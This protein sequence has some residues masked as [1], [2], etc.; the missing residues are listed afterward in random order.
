YAFRLVWEALHERATLRRLV[1]HLAKPVPF[2][3][4]IYKGHPVGPLKLDLGLWLYDAMAGSQNLGRHQRLSAGAMSRMEPRLLTTDLVG[5]CF[6]YDA[7]TDDAR[8]TLE[9]ARSAWRHGADLIPFARVEEWIEEGGAVRGVRV[10]DVALDS[11]ADL[12]EIRARCLVNAT[13]PWTDGVRGKAGLERPL[14]RTTKGVHLLI[15]KARLPVPHAIVMLNQPDHRILFV[16]PWGSLVIVGT[17]DTDYDGDPGEVRASAADVDYILGILRHYFPDQKFAREDVLSTYAG[18]RPLVR[19]THASAGTTSR[20]HQILEER[21][22]LFTVAGGKLTTYR[23]MA[24]QVVDRVIGA[25]KTVGGTK[26]EMAWP[27]AGEEIVTASVGDAPRGVDPAVWHHWQEVYGSRATK[28]A[29]LLGEKPDSAW[30]L[31]AHTPDVA[32]QVMYAART[33]MAVHLDD[34]LSR[35]T[36]ALLAGISLEEARKAGDAMGEVMGWDAAR[37]AAEV[38]RFAATMRHAH[39]WK[40]EGVGPAAVA[41]QAPAPSEPESKAASEPVVSEPTE[42]E[43]AS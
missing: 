29:T 6:Y 22:R 36:H 5:G 18:L 27:T 28:L 21:P 3:F 20:E 31:T 4:P 19:D 1:P 10:R 8:L 23:I 2:L 40:E 26:A 16:I 12:L 34:A 35:R 42:S 25:L 14:L 11:R 37:R 24:A 32:T 41:V 15:P 38:E 39:G 7:V 9:T 13:G 17:T 43:T 30:A 33:E